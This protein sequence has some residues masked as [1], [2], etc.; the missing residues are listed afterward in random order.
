MEINE[1]DSSLR[2]KIV[3]MLTGHTLAIVAANKEQSVLMVLS[4]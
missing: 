2:K 4:L 3:V 1:H